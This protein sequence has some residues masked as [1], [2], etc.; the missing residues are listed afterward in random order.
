MKNTPQLIGVSALL[1]FAVS[2]MP[3]QQMFA[4]LYLVTCESSTSYAFDYSWKTIIITEIMADPSPPQGLPEVEYVELFNRAAVSVSLEGW[5]LSDASSTVVLNAITLDPGQYVAI[6]SKPIAVA[7]NMMIV[8]GLPSLNNAGDS[9]MLTDAGNNVIDVVN[10]SDDWYRDEQ[11]SKGGW[12]LELIDV[13]NT[14]E[15]AGNWTVAD[16][17]MGGTPGK[18]NSVMASNPDVTGPLL[19]SV[20]IVDERNLRINFNERL[21][22]ATLQ[23]TKWAIIPS[24]ELTKLTF[25]DSSRMAIALV[26]DQ[27]LQGGQ[28]YSLTMGQVYDC[29]GNPLQ[30]GGKTTFALPEAAASGDVVI[31]EI[32]FNPRPDG[33]DFVEL[34][35]AS[36]KY[37]SLNGWAIGSVNDDGY[38]ERAIINAIVTL[39]PKQYMAF[40]ADASVLEAQYLCADSSITQLKLPS[41]ADEK[42]IVYISNEVDSTID[43]FEYNAAMHNAFVNDSEGISLERISSSAP[44]NDGSNWTSASS[45]AGFAT[46]GSGNSAER[47]ERTTEK[48]VTVAPSVFTPITG[49]PNFA[50]ISYQFE[51]PGCVA[52]VNIYDSRGMIVRHIADNILLSTEGKL[53]WDGDKDNGSK[54][55]SGYYVVWFQVYADD[56]T[57]RLFREAVA[58]SSRY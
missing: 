16:D 29:A 41:Y 9:L 50:E 26:L 51:Q 22:Q 44:S 57:S 54:A 25:I 46:P 13:N 45:S 14:C 58:I 4:H 55:L 8:S 34:F 11:R 33:V 39:H 56:G 32:L 35:N 10:Y 40:T 27:P 28:L 3:T 38:S 36:G 30:P 52:T 48:A 37:I 47:R 7:T 53:R 2:V 19:A 31:N 15:L 43:L 49:Q 5:K 23:S 6:A 42:G 1:T 17:S 18:E 24:V 20:D 21:S 12:S